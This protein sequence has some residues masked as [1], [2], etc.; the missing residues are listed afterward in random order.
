MWNRSAATRLMLLRICMYIC[1]YSL[2]FIQKLFYECVIWLLFGVL[3]ALTK[4]LTLT[5]QSLQLDHDCVWGK[6]KSQLINWKMPLLPAISY[7][8]KEARGMSDLMVEILFSCQSYDRHNASYLAA[9]YDRI[10]L[11]QHNQGEVVLWNRS[12]SMCLKSFVGKVGNW[13]YTCGSN[14][15]KN[16]IPFHIKNWTFLDISI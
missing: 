8:W 3:R 2:L 9:Q 1:I 15:H 6:K 13:I 16:L 12:D 14:N 10:Q 5:T 11:H 7:S 4:N